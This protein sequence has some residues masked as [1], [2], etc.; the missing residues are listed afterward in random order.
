MANINIMQIGTIIVFIG[1]IIIIIGSI[2]QT[3]EMR[4]LDSNASHPKKSDV[5]VA[6]GGFIGPLPFGFANDK[7][8]LY[9]LIGLMAF[10]LLLWVFLI[11][12][13]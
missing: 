8:V 2:M 7:I 11:H 13:K 1:M 10:T 6:V 4:R 5:R 12:Y 3:K 9:V